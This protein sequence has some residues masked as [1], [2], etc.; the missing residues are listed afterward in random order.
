MIAQAYLKSLQL[1]HVA[2][3]SSGTVA[4]ANKE[5][6]KPNLARTLRLLKR[7][8]VDT[9]AGVGSTQLTQATLEGNDVVVFM[10][11]I[12]YD[13]RPA[14]LVLPKT[15]HIWDVKDFDE[16]EHPPTTEIERME[17]A[18]EAYGYIVSKVDQLVRDSLL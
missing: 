5:A 13:D 4:G 3:V 15:V 18:E 16:L 17:R 8:N 7:H 11:K 10:S 9:F 2:V 1:P 6:N 12:A 14:A